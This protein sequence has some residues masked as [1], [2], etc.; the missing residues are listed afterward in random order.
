MLAPH[1]SDLTGPSSGAFFFISCICRFASGN[2]RTTRNGW[3]CRVVRVLPHSKSANTAY[4]KTLLKMDQW[5]PKHV[6]LTYVMNKNSVIKKKLCV[7]CWTAY[8]LQ[9]D[10]RSLKYQVNNGMSSIKKIKQKFMYTT[11][12]RRRFVYLTQN[13]KWRKY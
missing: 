9:D 13:N 12:R 1:V 3:T 6:E 4:K 5:G 11:L 10:T 7:S 8:I 2:T